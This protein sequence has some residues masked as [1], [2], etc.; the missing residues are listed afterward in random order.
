LVS[1]A[2]AVWRAIVVIN[3]I[4]VSD[5][6]VGEIRID[7]EESSARIAELTVRP[8]TADPFTIAAWSGKSIFINSLIYKWFL[9]NTSYINNLW[10]NW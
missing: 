6:V 5:K 10:W 2:A 3:A 9:W 8:A 4:D 7:A 1:G